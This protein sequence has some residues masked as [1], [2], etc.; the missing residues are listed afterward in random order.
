MILD[1]FLG[2]TGM[3]ESPLFQML[4]LSLGN[5]ALISLGEIEGDG[6]TIDVVSASHHI[7]V[8]K[9][10]REKTEGNLSSEEKKLLDEIIC[11]LQL[12]LIEKKK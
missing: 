9:M 10:I 7:E 1:T 2:A 4:V 3:E 6:K 5:A 8:L 11:D 12:K